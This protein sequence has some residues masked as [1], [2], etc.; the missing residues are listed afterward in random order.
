[1]KKVEVGGTCSTRGKKR[2][3]YK[4]FVR[5]LQEKEHVETLA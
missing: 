3:A 1:M 5:K 4:F 2:Y